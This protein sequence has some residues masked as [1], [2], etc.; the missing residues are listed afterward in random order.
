[1]QNRFH[2]PVDVAFQDGAM[3]D[4]FGRQRISQAVGVLEAKFLHDHLPYSHIDLTAGAGAITYLFSESACRLDVGTASGDR[5]VRESHRYAP[6][7][8]GN[9]LLMVATGLLGPAKHNVVSRIGLFN[10]NNGPFFER[11]ETDVRVVIRTN[12]SGTAS[13]AAFFTQAQW[14]LDTL[15]GSKSPSNSSGIQLDTTKAQ[16]F[17]IDFQWLGFGKVRFGFDFGGKVVY[18]HEASAANTTGVVYMRRPTLPMRYEIVNTGISPSASFMKQVCY[19]IKTEGISLLPGIAYSVSNGITTRAATTRLPILALR[20]TNTY[21]GNINR[22]QIRMNGVALYAKTND[23]FFEVA[24]VHDNWTSTTGGTWTPVDTYSGAEYNT[25]LTAIT[26]GTI[27]VVNSFFVTTGVGQTTTAII[28][29]VDIEGNH[30][31]INQN[32][33]STKSEM[34]VIFATSMSATTNVSGSIMFAEIE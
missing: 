1:M 16:I 14:N 7:V 18:C 30:A 9:S 26:G 34:V 6:Y 19:S 25:G 2:T 20:L 4:A 12:T 29:A 28:G 13:D 3:L 23:C 27:H 31:W 8:P 10:D 21:N 5:V 22:R 24:H 17:V 33:D 15:D 11:N 32:M